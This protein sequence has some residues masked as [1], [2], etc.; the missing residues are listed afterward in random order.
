MFTSRG[1]WFILGVCVLLAVAVLG[2]YLSDT[3]GLSEFG[4]LAYPASVA[5]I[6]LTLVVWFSWEWFHFAGQRAL[7]VPRLQVVRE[8]SDRRGPVETLWAGRTFHVRVTIQLP[9]GPGVSYVVLT[10]RLPRGGQLAHGSARY[11][12]PLRP[13]QPAVLSYDVHCPA[14]GRLRFEGLSLHMADLQ[15]F[16]CHASFLRAA[17]VLPVLPSLVDT[18]EHGP[19]LKRHN[20]L[21]PPGIHR[22]RRPGSGS[23]LLDLRDYMPGDPPKTI[24]WKV[25]ARRD[26]LMTKEFESEVPV[27]CTLFVDTSNSVRVGPAGQNALTRLVEIAAAVARAASN[28]RDLIGLCRFNEQSSNLVRPARG[29]RHL[30]RLLNL[31]A[32]AGGLPPGVG[33]A[34]ATDLLPL[35]YAFAQEVYPD[36]LQ[37]DLNRFPFWLAWLW[38]PPPYTVQRPTLWDHLYRWLPL[39]LPLYGILGL[40]LVGI[41]LIDVAAV[42]D[43]VSVP[44]DRMFLVLALAGFILFLLYLRLPSAVLFPRHRQRFRWRKQLAA[45]LAVR[46]DLAPGGLELLLE[47]D[48]RLSFYLQRFLIDHHVPY[49][50]ALYD[51]RGRYLY[52]SPGK[53]KVLSAALLRSVGKG[54]DNEL[55]VLLADLLELVDELGPLLAAVKVAL[56]RHHR[57]MVLCPWPPGIEAPPSQGVET[58][59]TN[60]DR[61][62]IEV[63]A[64]LAHTITARF[65]RAYFRLRRIFGGM[66]VPVVCA[67]SQDSARLILERLDLLREL[68]RT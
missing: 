59:I 57:V 43:F 28:N 58:R 47:D 22:H 49:P 18:G 24:A 48:E 45:A 61:L 41:C 31:L 26:R 60:S 14:V 64:A 10:D 37:R 66:G 53:V 16:F 51:A 20:R 30:V 46:Y 54:H 12:G 9:P 67:L 52:A 38:P 29:A 8:L 40:V 63:S 25:S 17:Q 32:E 36:M 42:F 65:H 4:P 34:S 7:L 19:T 21:L 44:P 50:L 23:E 35:A 56:A 68:R 39:L 27:R 5:L 6:A 15:G 1:R 13:G 3:M 2:S 62:P 33:Q 11:E 55:F